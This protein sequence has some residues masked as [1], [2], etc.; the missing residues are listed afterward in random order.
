MTIIYIILGVLVFGGGL[1]ATLVSKSKREERERILREQAE[2]TA[3]IEKERGQA[4]AEIR[5]ADDSELERRLG[6]FVRKP[7]ER[8]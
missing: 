7:P 1:V 5:S 3:R 2:D 4:D 8:G 6:R